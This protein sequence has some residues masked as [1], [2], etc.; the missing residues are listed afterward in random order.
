M[1]QTQHFDFEAVDIYMFSNDSTVWKDKCV[2]GGLHVHKILS[3]ALISLTRWCPESWNHDYYN[4]ICG[5][6]A[7][8]A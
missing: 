5:Y 8:V 4:T 7:T 6:R 1:P 3:H 2:A